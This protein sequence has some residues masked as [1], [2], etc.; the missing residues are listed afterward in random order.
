MYNNQ[1]FVLPEGI[2]FFRNGNPARA[3]RNAAFVDYHVSEFVDID[4]HIAPLCSDCQN[5]REQLCAAAKRLS[6]SLLR[7][8]L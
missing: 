2:L 6:D 4:T 8:I 7:V 5:V 1:V 3:V